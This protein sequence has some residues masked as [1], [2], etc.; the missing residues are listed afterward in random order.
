MWDLFDYK[1]AQTHDGGKKFLSAKRH[2]EYDC[3]D[4]R[5]RV[6]AISRHAE[7]LAKGEVLA[8]ISVNANW[9]VAASGT[10]DELLWR[11]A[12]GK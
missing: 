10:A 12:C 8:A 3:K 5:A 4:G 1:T 11:F 7:N 6:L 2:V 9:S